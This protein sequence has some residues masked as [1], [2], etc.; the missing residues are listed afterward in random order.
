MNWW[1]VLAAFGLVWEGKMLVN[2]KE[3]MKEKDERAKTAYDIFQV[4]MVFLSLIF[5]KEGFK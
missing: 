5:L 4:F 2:E 3:D 1:I